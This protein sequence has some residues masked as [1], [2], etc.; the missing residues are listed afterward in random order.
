MHLNA[1]R[2]HIILL[3]FVIGAITGFTQ[4]AAEKDRIKAGNKAF[5][6][7]QYMEALPHFQ[8]LLSLNESNPEYNFKYGACLVYKKD[9]ENAAKRLNYAVEN[10]EQDPRVYYFLGKLNQLNYSFS[11]AASFYERFGMKADDK[12]LKDYQVENEMNKCYEATDLLKNFSELKVYSKKEAS[13]SDFYRFYE[14]KRIGGKIIITEEFRTKTDKKND[15][16]PVIFLGSGQTY[17]LYASY[18]DDESNGKDLYM[19]VRQEDGKFGDPIRLPDNINTPYDEDFP[20]LAKDGKT[21]YFSSKGHTGLGGYDIFKTTFNPDANTASDPVN[22]DFKINSPDDDLFFIGEPNGDKAYFASSRAVDDSKVEVFDI[23]IKSFLLQDVLIAGEVT[24]NFTSSETK[25]KVEAID[26]ASNKEVEKV[27]IDPQNPNFL[28]TLPRGGKYTFRVSSKVSKQVVEASIDVPFSTGLKPL[29]LNIDYRLEDDKETIGLIKRFDQSLENEGEIIASYYRKVSKPEVNPDFD[30]DKNEET[31]DKSFVTKKVQSFID[32][33]DVEQLKLN[34]Q[35]NFAK[36]NAQKAIDL[37]IDNQ[38]QAEEAIAN[39]DYSNAQKFQT[40]ANNE[41]LNAQSFTNNIKKLN[42]VIKKNDVLLTQA[43]QYENQVATATGDELKNISSFVNDNQEEVILANVFQSS[44]KERQ[45]ELE[46]AEKKDLAIEQTIRDNNNRISQLEKDLEEASKRKKP[47]IQSQIDVLK[48]ENEMLGLKKE[49]SKQIVKALREENNQLANDV[50]IAGLVSANEMSSESDVSIDEVMAQLNEYKQASTIIENV[51][52]ENGGDVVDNTISQTKDTNST[53]TNENDPVID[54]NNITIDTNNNIVQ[55]KIGDSSNTNVIDTGL[56]VI[57]TVPQKTPEEIKQEELAEIQTKVEEV[58]EKKLKELEKTKKQAD[59][60]Y[61]VANQS[62]DSLKIVNRLLANASE[63]DKPKL[64]ADRKRLALKSLGY[65]KLME[66]YNQAMA[67]QNDQLAQGDKIKKAG[68]NIN[69]EDAAKEFLAVE[70]DVFS[71]SDVVEQKLNEK[72]KDLKSIKG[73]LGEANSKIVRANNE[74]DQL[75]NKLND[76]NLSSDDKKNLVREITQKSREIEDI[77]LSQKALFNQSNAVQNEMVSLMDQQDLMMTIEQNEE[78]PEFQNLP[79]NSQNMDDLIA[80]IKEVVPEN[81]LQESEDNLENEGFDIDSEIAYMTQMEWVESNYDILVQDLDEIGQEMESVPKTDRKYAELKNKAWV[82]QNRFFENN[83]E[84]QLKFFDAKSKEAVDGVDGAEEIRE[85]HLQIKQRAKSLFSQAQSTKRIDKKNELYKKAFTLLK[86]QDSELDSLYDVAVVNEYG[87]YVDKSKEE[88]ENDVKVLEKEYEGLVDQVFDL[89]KQIQDEKDQEKRNQLLEI[90]VNKEIEA[91]KKKNLIGQLKN[92]IKRKDTPDLAKISDANEKDFYEA[93]QERE[94]L[95]FQF[96]EESDWA[97]DDQIR[98]FKEQYA[99]IE[100]ISKEIESL[101]EEKKNAPESEKEDIQKRINTLSKTLIDKENIL[102]TQMIKG[103]Y[104]SI[105]NKNFQINQFLDGYTPNDETADELAR[106]QALLAAKVKEIDSLKA[107]QSDDEF[108]MAKVRRQLLKTQQE[109]LT[110]QDQVLQTIKDNPS[111]PETQTPKDDTIYETNFEILV[112]EEGVT[113]YDVNDPVASEDLNI[114]QNVQEENPEYQAFLKEVNVL[115]D[116]INKA[117]KGSEEHKKLKL[118]LTEKENDFLTNYFY[119]RFEAF[120]AKAELSPVAKNAFPKEKREAIKHDAEEIFLDAKNADDIAIKN[121]LLKQAFINITKYELQVDSIENATLAGRK[122]QYSK[123]NDQAIDYKLGNLQQDIFNLMSQ[124]NALLEQYNK[125]TD[126]YKKQEL[127]RQRKRKEAELRIAQQQIKELNEVLDERNGVASTDNNT[128][129]ATN[130]NNQSKEEVQQ[131]MN[132]IKTETQEQ[133]EDLKDIQT[134]L[135]EANNRQQELL[136]E[137]E[138]TEDPDKK[139]ELY[140]EYKGLKDLIARLQ[141]QLSEIQKSMEENASQLVALQNKYNQ[142]N[143]GSQTA[144]DNA[145]LLPTGA[146]NDPASFTSVVYVNQFRTK[147][148]Q[149]VSS[150]TKEN[151][152]GL[153]YKVQIGAFYKPVS[154]DNFR[155]FTPITY[156]KIPNSK[157]VRYYAGKFSQFDVANRA[158]NII[159]SERGYADA[160]VVAFYNGQRVSVSKARRLEQ[161]DQ[162]ILKEFKGLVNTNEVAANNNGGT[163]TSNT[164]NGNNGNTTGT[165]QGGN[166]AT[167]NNGNAVNNQTGTT[168][169]NQGGT[170]TTNGTNQGGTTTNTQGNTTNNSNTDNLNPG[171][172]NSMFFT[173]QVGALSKDAPV[174]AYAGVGEVFKFNLSNGYIRYNTGKFRTLEAAKARQAQIQS[175]IPD[176]FIVVYYDGKRVSVSRAQELLNEK[177]E[178]ILI[179]Q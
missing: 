81:Y 170:T 128:N 99:E 29:G 155:E 153:V 12:L 159:R 144:P 131:K 37:A 69:N 127:L 164:T 177:G 54:T 48:E 51:I 152:E 79:S 98:R 88:L 41:Y 42:E 140:D 93:R 124:V 24:G 45:K 50:L 100:K 18:G 112:S 32:Q 9:F 30:P 10:G 46:T 110:L 49:E 115:I 107:I 38:K 73:K 163:T 74:L 70:G 94:D 139:K 23:G 7:M 22:M 138:N 21:L 156:L 167:S 62:L 52:E 133:L 53:N 151:I 71:A 61:S 168:T 14:P 165:N 19:R 28:V 95:L 83:L 154:E 160:F 82:V 178:G 172:P 113:D 123:L 66:E 142:L 179:N 117:P 132:K 3:V 25:L 121:N 65:A 104:A 36:E 35:L 118:E 136:N 162:E 57:D 91:R 92:L 86:L 43:E 85:K 17:V 150:S 68:V 173:V 84:N 143:G 106:L 90:K 8:Y 47:D 137:I 44:Y 75:N 114:L 78:T 72:E 149:E 5:D 148:G 119:D 109:I 58:Q 111:E 60:T 4:D 76:A 13:K 59:F 174:T 126:P 102:F 56:V 169:N 147:D 77:A 89:T 161:G 120:S 176:A 157:Y 40:K 145:I 64:E 130:F 166:N 16:Q 134:Q 67:I 20:Y 96:I 116:K 33:K 108:E 63:E 101:Y 55:N 87:I 158:K 129:Q 122:D 175:T 125:E 27:Y 26:E 11:T 171:I 141:K 34:G 105:G 80:E 15:H 39:G 2:K 6:K 146:S 1:W 97:D 31:Y 103:S 135:G